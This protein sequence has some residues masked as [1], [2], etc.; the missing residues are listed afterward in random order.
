MIEHGKKRGA[1]KK[2]AEGEL[3]REHFRQC[4]NTTSCLQRLHLSH[5]IIWNNF[6]PQDVCFC[7]QVSHLA[8]VSSSQFSN[9]IAYFYQTGPSLRKGCTQRLAFT[10]FHT[11][12]LRI[13]VTTRPG[14]KTILWRVTFEEKTLSD[15]VDSVCKRTRL[16]WH[17][18]N[19]GYSFNC[20]SVLK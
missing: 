11:T 16:D 14:L 20:R 3:W 7:L 15:S 12:C 19:T 13:A 18:S 4:R 2:T 9:M 1:V 5:F 10:I 17:L 8:F 6:S